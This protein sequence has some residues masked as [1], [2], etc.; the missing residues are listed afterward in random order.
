MMWRFTKI[1]ESN[2]RHWKWHTEIAPS[3]FWVKTRGPFM[4]WGKGVRD[5]GRVQVRDDARV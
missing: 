1:F 3:G 4:W 2:P 5:A